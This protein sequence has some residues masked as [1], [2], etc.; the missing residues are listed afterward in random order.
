MSL[1]DR[2]ALNKSIT[3]RGEIVNSVNSREIYEYLEV[4]TK[5]AD[6]IKRAIDK[7]DFVD[8]EDFIVLK[9]GNGTN[10][11]IDYIVTMDMAKEL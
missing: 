8:G 3:K 6:W 4:G 1:R 9:N 11:F 5:Y 10:A 7:Y 2:Q